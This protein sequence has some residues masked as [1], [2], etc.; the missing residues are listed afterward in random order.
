MMK[1][2]VKVFGTL[3]PAVPEYDPEEG[4]ELPMADGAKVKDLLASLEL[5]TGRGTV[6]ASDGRIL[7]P[8]DLLKDGMTV[9]VLQ[10]V[11]GG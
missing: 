7:G 10:T 6:A 5:S 9:E 8:E 4:L 3:N 11:F 2:R 1:V